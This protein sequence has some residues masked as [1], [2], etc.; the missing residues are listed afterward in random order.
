MV[1]L[2]HT[3]THAPHRSNHGF[4]FNAWV[5]QGVSFLSRAEEAAIEAKL[6]ARWVRDAAA[7]VAA[8]AEKEAAAAIAAVA[9]PQEKGEEDEFAVVKAH[10][11]RNGTTF[12]SLSE[13]EQAMILDARKKVQQYKTATANNTINDS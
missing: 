6:K 3:R 4:D 9:E 2:P 7:A 5:G 12:E 1:G 8:A 11:T 13:A 10:T